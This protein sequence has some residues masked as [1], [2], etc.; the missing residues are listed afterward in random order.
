MGSVKSVNRGQVQEVEW[1]GTTYR[2]G[3]YKRPVQGP[4]RVEGVALV[5]DE[6]ADL[7]VHGGKDK[8]VYAYP[9]EHYDFWQQELPSEQRGH[10]EVW[11]AFGEN[12]T[13]EGLT[14]HD[15][16][17]GD[18][19]QIG[20]TRLRVTEPRMPCAT[21]GL[22][23]RDPMMTKRFY[24]AERNGFYLTID[25]AGELKAG[26]EITIVERHPQR[27][28]IAQ[29]ISLRTETLTDPEIL[30]LALTHPGLPESLRERL[31]KGASA[32]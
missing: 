12:L 11:G 1:R 26:D 2:T 10:L 22:R 14:E 8:S 25:Q 23:F 16:G 21:L 7:A 17:I 29:V 24:K 15:V 32:D 5:G 30:A 13:I 9:V 27:L 18:V 3:I 28:S 6:Q 4:I 20:T 31:S 19:L